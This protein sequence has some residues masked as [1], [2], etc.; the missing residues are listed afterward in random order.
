VRDYRVYF[1]NWDGHIERALDMECEDDAAATEAVLI[2]GG[3][4]PKELW[5]HDRKVMVFPAH[6]TH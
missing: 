5:E 6:Q 2:I 3:D 1:L 4:Q